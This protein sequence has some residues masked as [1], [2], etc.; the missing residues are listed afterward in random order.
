MDV[1]SSTY[2]APFNS[3]SFAVEYGGEVVGLAVSAAA[4]AVDEAGGAVHHYL[5]AVFH[6][7]SLLEAAAIPGMIASGDLPH[8]PSSVEQVRAGESD[9]GAGGSGGGGGGGA[10][11][12]DGAGAAEGGD[13]AGAEGGDAAEGGYNGTAAMEWLMTPREVVLVAMRAGGGVDR[14]SLGAH[15]LVSRRVLRSSGWKV[16]KYQM[17]GSYRAGSCT[18]FNTLDALCVKVSQGAGGAWAPDA[19]FGGV[20]CSP[21]QDWDPVKVRRIH[22]PAGGRLPR[23]STVRRLGAGSVAVRSAHDPHIAALNVTGGTMFFAERAAEASATGV[24]LLIIG[25]VLLL[26]GVALAAP[27][28]RRAARGVTIFSVS[29]RRER[30][31]PAAFDDI[32]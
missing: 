16:C 7:D 3:T 5:P 8:M 24:V 1:W 30:S 14:I 23:L 2:A 29:A 11:D 28:V 18:T 4:E 25:T 6:L 21:R 12:L 31:S 9:G 20:G 19:S 22:A 26:P 27:Y 10:G 13:A 15:A 17:A 32:L